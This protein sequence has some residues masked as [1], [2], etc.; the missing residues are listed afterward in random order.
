MGVVTP[1]I[2]TTANPNRPSL[3]CLSALM[4]VVTS[5]EVKKGGPADVSPMPFGFDGSGYACKRRASEKRTFCLQCLSALMGV[6]TAPPL[7]EKVSKGSA[8]PMPFGF[9]GSGYITLGHLVG[10]ILC[11]VSNAFRL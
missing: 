6:V 8:S 2:E 7:I 11:G 3:Q 4:G 9:D 5:P 10:C 1:M